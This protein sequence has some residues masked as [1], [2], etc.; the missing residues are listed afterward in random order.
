MSLNDAAPPSTS[1]I[2]P[3]QARKA[4]VGAL[5]GTSLEFYD[6][7]VYATASALVFGAVFFPDIAD[8]FVATMAA[9]GVFGVGFI[10]RP[11]GAVIFGHF[12][13]KYGRKRALIASLLIMGGSTFLV[14]FL[15]TYDTAGAVAPLALVVLRLLQGFA[16]GGEWGGAALISTESAPHNRRNFYGAFTQLG[17]PAGTVMASG[18]FALAGL[19]GHDVLL[20]WAWRVPF[21]FSGVLIIVGLVIR[22]KLEESPAFR[23]ATEQ[24]RVVRLPIVT[25]LRVQ[26]K[27]VLAGVAAVAVGIGG[28]YITGTLFLSY[29]TTQAGNPESPLLLAQTIAAASSIISFPLLALLADRIGAKPVMISGLVATYLIAAPH[30]LVANTNSMVLV[31]VMLVITQTVQSGAWVCIPAFLSQAFPPETRYTGISLSYQLAAILFGGIMPVLGAGL[32][33]RTGGNPTPAI[34][35]L[36][37]L[38]TVNIVG[39]IA[40]SRIVTKREVTVRGTHGMEGASHG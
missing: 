15:P 5:A 22:A 37:V 32:L 13:D 17:S 34:V 21:W 31:G 7:Y 27:S 40:V 25:V 18:M 39:V 30:F 28:F 14:G 38:A 36:F 4:A 26:W 10:S 20:D 35:L 9:F 1:P 16:I 6:F 12:G 11:L 3:K 24:Q 23:A 2:A 19:G 29:A 8:P 33:A